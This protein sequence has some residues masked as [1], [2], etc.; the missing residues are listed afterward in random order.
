MGAR[1][2]K[3]DEAQKFL[4]AANLN[5]LPALF[6]DGENGLGLVINQGGKYLPNIGA[7]ICKEVEGYLRREHAYGNK[8]TG[9]TVESYFQGHGYGWD[10]EM[11]Q[12]VLAVLLRGGAIEVVYQGRRYRNHS[13]P[14]SREPFVNTPAFRSA[15]FAP[16]E[17][18]DLRMLAEA[19]RN[20]ES[21]T[22]KEVD[23]EEGA[24]A[25]EFQ[26]LA[27]QDRELLLPL[28]ARMKALDLPGIAGLDE[29]FQTV[30]GVLEMPADDCVKTLAGEGK[31]YKEVR[32]RAAK[33]ADATSP[34]N[35]EVMRL[36]RRVINEQW[37]ALRARAADDE[38]SA[39]A[40][41]LREKIDSASFFENIEAIRL[42]ASN[43]AG[44]YAVLYEAAHAGRAAA[45]AAAID[46]IRGLPEWAE[47]SRLGPNAGDGPISEAERT[48]R[49]LNERALNDALRPLLSKDRED[50]MLPRGDTVCS[51]CH[52]TMDQM[53]SDLAAVDAL[54]AQAL[55]NIQRLVAPEQRVVRVRVSQLLSS[56]LETGEDVEAALSQLRKHLMKLLAEG[57]R[58]ILE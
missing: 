35:L 1:Q 55:G 50:P 7:D 32:A 21:I 58:I 49:E 56:R 46:Q 53:E 41:S 24:I 29:F 28:V 52:A 12:L 38:T 22:G 34:E 8:L 13:D 54:R 3:G 19:A 23:I 37:P 20:F 43:L 44:N 40:A 30:D 4:A 9:K 10:R 51:R 33:L 14:A 57:A 48:R 18:L 15:S 2:L 45:Y 16:R 11:L 36:A 17:A 5:G 39:R 42:L 6:H 47:V 27:D 26:K 25:A 31:S